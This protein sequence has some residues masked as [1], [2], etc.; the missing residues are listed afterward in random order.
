MKKIWIVL[1]VWFMVVSAGSAM[2]QF[3]DGSW[4]MTTQME[5]KGMPHQMPPATFRQCI[6]KS[7][8]VV[9]NQEKGYDCKTTSLKVSGGT[10]A[11]SV[12]CKGKDGTMVSTGTNTYTGSTMSGTATI[13]LKM[14]GQPGMQ[15]T[16]R[17]KGKYIGPCP[18]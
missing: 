4:E 11:Y 7:D 17:M 6:T 8:P 15:M 12:E 18:K 2:A 9:K 13:S 14:K 1:M 5:M 16:S 10:V 3:K